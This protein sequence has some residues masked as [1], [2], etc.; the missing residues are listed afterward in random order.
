MKKVK[1]L[2]ALMIAW[3]FALPSCS[4]EDVVTGTDPSK[5]GVKDFTCVTVHA[6]RK[7]E[8]A[9]DGGDAVS[10][11]AQSFSVQLVE[12]LGEGSQNPDMYESTLSVTVAAEQSRSSYSGE[13]T[14]A[15]VGGKYYV[16]IRANYRRSLYSEWTYLTDSGG[17]PALFKLGRGV[18]AEGLEDPYLYKAI[19]IAEGFIVKWDAI[20]GATSYYVEWR[21][22]G[23]G[24]WSRHEADSSDVKFRASG[25]PADTE[26]EVRAMT[27]YGE[28]HSDY[29]ES[30][31]V[32]TKQPG[33]YPRQMTTA[34]ELATWLE[35]GV[36]EAAD[37]DVYEIM[38]DIDMTGVDFSAMEEGMAGIF[39]GNGFTVSGLSSQMFNDVEGT[40]RN[41]VL[42]GGI[43]SSSTAVASLALTNRG[44]VENVVSGVDISH[45][46]E[47]DAEVSMGGIVCV[48]EGT[49]HGCRNEGTISFASK[50]A[51]TKAVVMGGI[52]ASSTG[53][54]DGCVNAGTVSFTA[55]ASVRGLAVAGVVGCLESSM[56]GC[57]NRAAVT[58]SALYADGKCS[59]GSVAKAT[60]GVAGLVAYGSSDSFSME[61]C[62][63]YS[64]VS[65]SLSAIDKYG[66]T[67]ERVQ[68]AGVVA[69]PNGSVSSC[70]NNA[71]VNVSV[72][73]ST[74]SE[75][76]SS[77]HI[78]CIGGI[79]GGDY[80]ATGQSA[81]NYDGCVNNG[82]VTVRTDASKSN[83]AVGGICGWPGKEGSR[84]NATTACRNTASVTFTGNGK[85]RVGGIHGG[86]GTIVSC[87]NTGDVILS[88]SSTA[89]AAG[90]LA[91][92]SS[93]G[94]Q[95]T[96]SRNEGR[97]S[98]S[99][100]SVGGVGGM[101]GNLGNSKNSGLA[102]G[103]SVSC[104]VSNGASDDGL[105]YTGL[106]VGKFNG[107]SAVTVMG[108]S[109]SPVRVSGEVSIGGTAVT[110]TADNYTKWL[111]GTANYSE[112]SHPVYASFDGD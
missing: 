9:W 89:S 28:G 59:V 10:A 73:S 79:G 33:T 17:E 83:S 26:Y 24:D 23:G 98:S 36:A 68:V 20:P 1:T 44:L 41:L 13:I 65:Y 14:G 106:L 4:K 60:P 108:K 100:A 37:G 55:D 105:T 96:G 31:T 110:L 2:I 27:V 104:A 35:A 67:Y 103:N 48:N 5:P 87:I 30:L 112:S 8:L 61:D 18:I 78:V 86:S 80:F 51:L 32:S 53:P 66:S 57:E 11:G 22:S 74:G 92:F 93:N 70:S 71:A 49:L 3:A 43:E 76:S 47:S 42:E 90:G 62:H 72:K 69:N 95:V 40:V 84:K 109:A 99:V 88:T 45:T 64:P 38:N 82:K 97:V 25:L 12:G 29:C 111:V 6:S 15:A 77:G 81:T 58:V 102:E 52:A 54:V 34:D 19:G 101:I 56:T 39:E 85:G 107:T 16:R 91:G 75:Y 63:N 7:V 21:P 50:D 46:A 94:F